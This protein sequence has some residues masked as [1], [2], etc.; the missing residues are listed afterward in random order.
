MIHLILSENSILF[1]VLYLQKQGGHTMQTQHLTAGF[2]G[3]G[4]IGGSIARGSEK[5][6]SVH[7]RY[8]LYALP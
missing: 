4:L 2:Y 7:Y 6:G 1:A 3:L 5:T 8:G